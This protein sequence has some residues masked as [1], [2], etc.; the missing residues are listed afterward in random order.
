MEVTDPRLNHLPDE[1]QPPDTDE[2]SPGKTNSVTLGLADFQKEGPWM[3][4]RNGKME[5]LAEFG[6][7]STGKPWQT[8]DLCTKEGAE[9]LALGTLDKQLYNAVTT[10]GVYYTNATININTYRTNVLA[11]AFY[12]LSFMP[13]PNTDPKKIGK[14]NAFTAEQARKIATQIL[15]QRPKGSYE[16]GMDWANTAMMQDGK[17][18][19][20]QG[21]TRTERES[22]LRNTDGL[23]S[24]ADSLFTVILVAQS[25]KEGPE[26]KNIGKW[27]DE[28][29]VTGERRG[30]ALVWRDPFKT[31]RNLNHEMMVRMFRFLND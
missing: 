30:V 29:Q 31:G 12:D 6:Y 3:Y 22:V 11:S 8:I 28:D 10:N 21:L 9:F 20:G 1:W 15:E 5:S 24:V 23:F 16:S 13:T 27:D 26:E 25:V 4:C 19:D 7:F 18:L 17:Y 14:E 2:G